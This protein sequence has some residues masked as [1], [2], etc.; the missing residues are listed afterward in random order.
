MNDRIWMKPGIALALC[1]LLLPSTSVAGANPNFKLPLHA[2]MEPNGSCATTVDCFIHLPTINV[3]PGREVEIYL[4]AFNHTR[5]T[6]LQTAFSWESQFGWTFLSSQWD[7]LPGQVTVRQPQDPGG[8]DAGRL[9]T[10][11]DCVLGPQVAVIGSMRFVSGAAG[12]SCLRQVEPSLPDRILAVD[13]SGGVDY[14]SPAQQSYS[15]GKICVINGGYDSCGVLPTP[16]EAST[17]GRIKAT[18]R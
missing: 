18:Y 10:T 12:G 15:L 5:L 4:L 11:F 8:P 13:C 17:W 16:S 14:M 1:F 2:T 3:L 6:G 9:M 7:C